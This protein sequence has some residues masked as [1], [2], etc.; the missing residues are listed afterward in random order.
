MMYNVI[1]KITEKSMKN[2]QLSIMLKCAICV[3]FMCGFIICACWYPFS[4]PLFTTGPASD[5]PVPAVVAI[6][7]QIAFYWAVSIPCFVILILFWKVTD[8]IVL[9]EFFSYKT[10][11][12]IKMCAI[13]LFVDILIY[14]IG[15]TMI[16]FN[17]NDTAAV[18][19][20]VAILGL[21]VTGVFY[22]LSHFVSK[23]AEY[24]ADTEGLI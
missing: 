12:E 6:W 13:I 23:A 22:A 15:N 17:W 5:L 7:T 11:K 21:A 4:V 16:M 3:F 19:Y 1:I 2:L 18:N 9:D 10:A 20:G 24:K 8:S 14:V